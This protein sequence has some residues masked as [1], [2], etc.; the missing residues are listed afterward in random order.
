M[1]ISL[2]N[3]QLILVV[4]NKIIPAVKVKDY[5][6]SC[7]TWYH[8]SI[9]Y[10]RKEGKLRILLNCEEVIFFSTNN[11]DDLGKKGEI[12]LGNENLEGEITEIRIWNQVIPVKYLV[13]NHKAPLPILA[14][15]K[16]KVKMKINKQEEKKKDEKGFGFRNQSFLN[17]KFSKPRESGFLNQSTFINRGTAKTTVLNPPITSSVA[18]SHDFGNPVYKKENPVT[19][20]KPIP[21]ENNMLDEDPKYPKFTFEAADKSKME[22]ED[23]NFPPNFVSVLQQNKDSSNNVPASFNPN[24]FDF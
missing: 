14:E 11:L 10:R 18:Q 22:G 7:H 15:C 24:D 8:L 16:R 4:N 23:P 19:L 3:N 9:Q 1:M 5:Q 21:E 12:I 13:N 2:Q 20:T 17:T 6:F